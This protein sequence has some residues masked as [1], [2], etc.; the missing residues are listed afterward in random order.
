M[1]SRNGLLNPPLQVEYLISHL[2]RTEDNRVARL[3]LSPQDGFRDRLGLLHLPSISWR[4]AEFTLPNRALHR[5]HGFPDRPRPRPVY[6]PRW[7]KE[8]DSHPRTRYP[9]SE[10]QARCN[11][12]LCH[13]SKLVG[14]VGFAPT[15]CL[16]RKQCDYLLPRPP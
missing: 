11:K 14:I 13:P 9:V 10:V 1:K 4:R 12:L 15:L 7:R 16:R 3:W 2:K 8:W 5:S 6:S